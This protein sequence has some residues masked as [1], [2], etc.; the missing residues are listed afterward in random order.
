MVR[1]KA[2]VPT[3][4]A[5]EKVNFNS[6][7]VR[8]KERVEALE[9]YEHTFQFQNGAIK[10]FSDAGG[11]NLHS[12]FN[13]KMVRLKAKNRIEYAI[14]KQRFQFQNGA[15]KSMHY[16]YHEM[17]PQKFQFQNGAIKRISIGTDIEQTIKF[18]FQNGA[19]KRAKAIHGCLCCHCISIPKWCD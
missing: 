18:Q 13:S 9:R 14:L 6:K 19:I 2:I 1:L 3:P 17:P 12:N 15:I 8:L 4:D 7:M 5:L 16:S 10:S 11:Q